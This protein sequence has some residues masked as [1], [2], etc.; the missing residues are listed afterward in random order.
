MQY[1]YRKT[2]EGIRRFKH[3]I[4]Y[5]ITL[6]W[7][8]FLYLIGIAWHNSYSG[9]CTPDFNCCEPN[10]GRWCWLNMRKPK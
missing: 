6:G 9:E 8:Y 5:C 4:I 3:S 2:K 1:D 10:I 7:Q